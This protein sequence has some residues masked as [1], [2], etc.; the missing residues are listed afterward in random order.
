MRFHAVLDAVSN[1]FIL[2]YILVSKAIEIFGC[3]PA[4]NIPARI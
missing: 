3:L 2:A 1:R 4:S